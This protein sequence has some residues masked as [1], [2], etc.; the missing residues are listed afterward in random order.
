MAIT[1]FILYMFLLFREVQGK[2]QMNIAKL[3]PVGYEVQTEKG[4][5]YKHSNAWKSVAVAAIA[6]DAASIAMA[7]K[8]KNLVYKEILGSLG[9]K[10]V[11]ETI[12]GIFKFKTPNKFYKPVLAATFVL[13]SAFQWF[14]SV[15]MDNLTNNTRR[16]KADGEPVPTAANT[17]WKDL[18]RMPKSDIKS[19]K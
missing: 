18:L 8:I 14:T 19:N 1:N 4:N 7:P 9:S 6:L 13:G 2:N 17:K 16:M 11:L 10:F 3:N 12:E 15:I 5:K